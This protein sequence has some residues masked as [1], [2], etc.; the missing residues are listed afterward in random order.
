MTTPTQKSLNQLLAFL[1]LHQHAKNQFIPSI[2]SWDTA[3]FRVLWPDWPHPFLTMPTQKI[4]DQLLICVNL[5]QHVKNRFIPYVHSSDSVSFRVPWLDWPHPFLTMPTPNNFNQLLTCMNLYQLA[6]SQLRETQSI[7]ES[8]EQT[9]HTHFWPY[10]TKKYSIN[11]QLLWICIN[12][13]HITLF[14][15]FFVWSS[16]FKNPEIW[17]AESILAFISGTNFHYITNSVKINDQIFR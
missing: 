8:Q 12:I 9:G 14:H 15:H 4:S 13:Q 2:H 5:Y 17:L 1:N 16:W 3:N 7:L 11:L 6:K 10:P